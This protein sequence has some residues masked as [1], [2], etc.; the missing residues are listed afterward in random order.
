MLRQ[1]VE[2]RDVSSDLVYAGSATRWMLRVCVDRNQSEIV[3]IVGAGRAQ[4]R[5]LVAHAVDLFE[6]ERLLVELDGSVELR[7]V[8]DCVVESCDVWHLATSPPAPLHIVERGVRERWIMLCDD[9][10]RFAL[11]ST[12][13]GP[14]RI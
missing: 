12:G 11:I 8:E 14:R 13:I 9:V 5:H 2:R 1:P 3:M 7:D 10:S 4:E 6:A